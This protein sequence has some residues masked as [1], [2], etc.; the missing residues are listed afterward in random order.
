MVVIYLMISLRLIEPSELSEP[1]FLSDINEVTVCGT[2]IDSNYFIHVFFII[3]R[4][5]EC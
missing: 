2:I 4:S 1:A 5:S 3:F